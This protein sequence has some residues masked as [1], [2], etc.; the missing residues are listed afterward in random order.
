VRGRLAALLLLALAAAPAC[1]RSS[2]TEGE[3]LR[4]EIESLTQRRDALRRSI[5]EAIARD[6]R[7]E[8][9]PQAPVRVR[10]PT[11][12]VRE[13]VHALADGY[14]HQVRLELRGIEA[15]HEDDV[16][17]LFT[18]GQY[19]LD[20]S[21]ERITGR[22]ELERPLLRFGTDEVEA[23]L[24]VRIVSGHATALLRFH[25]DGSGLADAVCGDLTVSREVAGRVEPRRYELR[26]ALELSG[27]GQEIV[28][29]P[30]FPPTRVRLRIAPSPES[31]R[32]VA[33]ILDDEEG[34]CGFVLDK[35][36]L[37]EKLKQE[38]D[39]GIEVRLP[40][41][42]LEA[43]TM[44]VAVESRLNLRGH[45]VDLAVRLSDFEVSADDVWLGATVSTPAGPRP[46]RPVK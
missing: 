39:E 25:W 20:A 18:L 2:E 26:G 7:L 17:R 4:A 9:M 43:V 34:L 37:L 3:A 32:E 41:E 14:F 19:R 29:T 35:S 40:T 21:F 12:L 5:D 31:W 8:E 30:R 6:P 24:P 15:H 46:A 23:T 36:D 33:G 38:L 28:A 13:L 27:S 44:P 1:D 16:K 45:E 42:K 11:A 10:T 22:L